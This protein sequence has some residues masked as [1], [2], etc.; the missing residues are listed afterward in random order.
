LAEQAPETYRLFFA[1]SGNIP[2][3]DAPGTI[4]IWPD[5]DGW[6]DFGHRIRAEFLI[7]PRVSHPHYGHAIRGKCFLGF[8]PAPTRQTD[9]NWLQILGRDSNF[10]PQEDVPDFFTMLPDLSEYR[11]LVEFFGPD[12]ARTILLALHDVVAVA[13]VA[14]PPAW[15]RWATTGKVFLN[16]FLR[17]TESYYAWK[18]AAPILEGL[19]FEE[20]GRISECLAIEFQLGGWSNKHSLRFKFS[21][22]EEF[23]P[24]R[25]AIIIG[26]NGVGKSQTLRRIATAALRGDSSLTDGKGGRPSFNRLLA[27]T[28]TLASASVFPPMRRRGARVWYQRFSLSHPG[29]GRRRHPTGD[30]ILQL[31]RTEE[32]V[33]S[34]SRFEI[35]LRSIQAIEKPDRL[36]LMGRRGSE[37]IEITGLRLG[38]EQA[39]IERFASIDPDGDPVRLTPQGPFPLSSGELAFVRFAAT[40]ALHVENGSLLLFDEPETHLHPNFIS[41]FVALL[42]N[43]L[44][45]TGSVA[46]IATHSAYFVREAFDDQVVVLRSGSGNAIEV[47]QPT[48]TTFGADVGAISYFVFGEDEPSRL[49]RMVER[50]IAD[51]N[52]D[53][54]QILEH[55]KGE[56]SLDLLSDIRAKLEGDTNGASGS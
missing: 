3:A 39:R 26:K 21:I 43:L 45:Q 15:L 56:I 51:R 41:Q 18:N 23:L 10:M 47:E 16:G 44:E 49:A 42:D 36:A 8:M 17:Q 50:R 27:F 11:Q 12:E 20:M 40:A 53:W 6:N 7:R 30:Q 28:G 33:G 54:K 13:E 48:L 52:L 25:F 32:R 35:F 24:K 46:I 29:M 2:Q 4:T 22:G 5:N 38:G 31:A 19:A 14:S 9:T 55:Y 1:L 37:P 34:L